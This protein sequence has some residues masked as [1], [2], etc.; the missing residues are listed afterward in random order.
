MNTWKLCPQTKTR[1]PLSMGAAVWGCAAAVAGM[2]SATSAAVKRTTA[3]RRMR[4]G[5]RGIVW[6]LDNEVGG[7]DECTR[8]RRNVERQG[9]RATL[10]AV[11][12]TSKVNRP[13]A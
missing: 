7:C 11:E 2:P 8:P 9:G 12:E 10:T 13:G 5:I 4:T 1:W 3:V 6:S